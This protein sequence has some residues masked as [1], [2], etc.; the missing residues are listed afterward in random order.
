M[1]GGVMNKLEDFTMGDLSGVRKHL[2]AMPQEIN[3]I[4]VLKDL[5]IKYFGPNHSRQVV[6]C[7]VIDKDILCTKLN[8]RPKIYSPETCL[9]ITKKENDSYKYGK[10][11]GVSNGR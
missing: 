8:I 4:I 2:G 3:G 1:G 9:W 5:G 6:Q 11:K 10:A 7:L